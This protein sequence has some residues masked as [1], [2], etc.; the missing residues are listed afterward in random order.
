M[1]DDTLILKG[2]NK[3]LYSYEEIKNKFYSNSSNIKFEDQL[4]FTKKKYELNQKNTTKTI[5]LKSYDKRIFSNCKKK[6][7]PIEVSPDLYVQ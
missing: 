3:N 6:T 5:N 1:K 4:S 2:V 7:K